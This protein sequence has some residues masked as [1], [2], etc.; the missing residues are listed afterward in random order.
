ME[1]CMGQTQYGF[2]SRAVGIAMLLV[3]HYHGYLTNTRLG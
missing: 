1:S 3:G 2:V